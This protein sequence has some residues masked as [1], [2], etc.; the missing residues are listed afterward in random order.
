LEH[1][2]H[3]EIKMTPLAFLVPND[4]HFI[5][6]EH[7][8]AMRPTNFET[9]AIVGLIDI[10]RR[11]VNG[12]PALLEFGDI[13]VG[14]SAIFLVPV[15]HRTYEIDVHVAPFLTALNFL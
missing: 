10:A 6:L 7:G 14:K 3:A 5:A 9:D 8:F 13:P 11:I 2:G 4:V 15:P 12:N 1:E